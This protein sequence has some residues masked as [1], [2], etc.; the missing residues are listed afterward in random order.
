M[1]FV[2]WN[3]DYCYAYWNSN[4]KG[5]VYSRVH[6]APNTGCTKPRT[7]IHEIL[8]GIG[9]M[10][11]QKR[12]DRDR[13]I[14]INWNNI[15]PSAFEEFKT[16][17]GDT[18]G[19]PYDCGSVMHYSKDAFSSNGGDTITSIHP[20]CKLPIADEWVNVRP[21]MSAGDIEAIKIQYCP[22]S[23]EPSYEHNYYEYYPNYQ[24][25][26]EYYPNYQETYEYYPD[27]NPFEY[28]NFNYHFDFK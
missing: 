17:D 6:L 27:Y 19:I 8:H 10:H 24:E 11:I 14:R 2:T 1:D 9:F 21:M 12:P 7:I 4:G 15:R 26:Y 18:F 20:N 25:T 16:I 28:F 13:Y 5:G 3:K 23:S 22:S